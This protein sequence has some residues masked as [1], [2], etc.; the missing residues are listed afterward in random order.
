MSKPVLKAMFSF[1]IFIAL[2]LK[3]INK[4]K[5]VFISGNETETKVEC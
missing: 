5:K 1:Q 2:I 3:A 4:K